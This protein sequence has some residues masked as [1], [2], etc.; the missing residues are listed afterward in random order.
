MENWN[1][2]SATTGGL[3]TSTRRHLAIT[4]V[5]L[6]TARAFVTWTHRYLAP[7]ADAEIILGVQAGTSL[8]GV[9]F[10]GAL[11]CWRHDDGHTAE[12]V[13]LSTDGTPNACS[14]LLGA[15]RRAART[16]GYRRLIV[17]TRP[18]ESGASLRAAGSHPMPGR[19]VDGALWEI[20]T[21]GDRR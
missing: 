8:A 13:C 9:V 7:P 2:T 15:A 14:A 11:A 10:V 17:R 20:R 19:A 5:R 1:G 6:R 12:I 3:T 21:V 16:K 18:G 4:P